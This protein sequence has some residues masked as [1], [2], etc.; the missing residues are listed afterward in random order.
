MSMTDE[1]Q[2][3]VFDDILYLESLINV[4]QKTIKKNFRARLEGKLGEDERLDAICDELSFTLAQVSA[5]LS[6]IEQTLVLDGHVTTEQHESLNIKQQQLAAQ[7]LMRDE[8]KLSIEKI[9]RENHLGHL[10]HTSNN[11]PYHSLSPAST[12]KLILPINRA[13][14]KTLAVDIAD[15]SDKQLLDRAVIKVDGVKL[16][17]KHAVING[18]L[19]L[20]C[21]IPPSKKL[22]DHTHVE[23]LTPEHGGDQQFRFYLSDVHCVPKSSML[24]A[25]KTL[26]K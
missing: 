23:L 9:G 25:I 5:R 16:K 14:K 15:V 17:H 8:C 21:Y 26:L 2:R 18:Q 10:Q 11:L 20:L 6:V 4:E 22:S 13:S 12:V 3:E 1:P 24:K 19:R 7:S